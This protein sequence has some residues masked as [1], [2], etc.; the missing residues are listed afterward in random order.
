MKRSLYSK[1]LPAVV[2][3]TFA[4]GNGK[5]A[6]SGFPA[7]DTSRKRGEHGAP[8]TAPAHGAPDQERIDSLKQEKQKGKG[9]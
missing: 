7:E 6:N 1:L 9:Q 2:L 8:Q 4:C 3:L 5:N